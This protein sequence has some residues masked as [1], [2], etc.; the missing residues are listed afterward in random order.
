MPLLSPPSGHQASGWKDFPGWLLTLLLGGLL[1]AARPAVAQ[2]PVPVLVEGQIADSLRTPLP[3]VSVYLT[4]PRGRAGLVYGAADAAGRFALTWPANAPDTLLLQLRLI[5]FR[6]L[7]RAVVRTGRP[8]PDLN[9]VMQTATTTLNEVVVRA[10]RGIRYN[11]TTTYD[12]A[13]FRD[14]TQRTLEEVLKSVPGFVVAPDGGI[15]YK[16]KSIAG[17]FL[18]GENLTGAN[19]QRLTRNLDA[20]LVDKIQPVERFVENKLLGGL[21]RS[22]TTV[23]NITIPAD[24]KKPVFG[25]VNAAAALPGY[26]DATANVFSMSKQR[27]LFFIGTHNNIGERKDP[28]AES[29][30]SPAATSLRT[31]VQPV[32]ALLTAPPLGSSDFRPDLS[33]L[34]NETTGG[35]VHVFKPDSSRW[36]LLSDISLYHDAQRQTRRADTRYLLGDGA[37][38][39]LGEI[40]RARQTTN[41]ARLRNNLFVTLG[42]RANLTYEN[43]LSVLGLDFQDALHLNTE[44][45]Q[46]NRAES[47]AQTLRQRPVQLGQNLL[48][49]NRLSETAALQTQLT[50][51]YDYLP[52]HFELTSDAPERRQAYLG[53]P[54][55]G[56]LRQ[57][58]NTRQ[59]ALSAETEYFQTGR[60]LNYSAVLGSEFSS[61]RLHTT[62]APILAADAESPAARGNDLRV[63]RGLLYGHFRF[64]KTLGRLNLS[65]SVGAAGL[66]LHVADSVA[67]R[68]RFIY[69]TGRLA[70]LYVLSDIAKLQ[71]HYDFGQRFSAPADLLRAPVLAD[72]RTLMRGTNAVLAQPEQQLG[73]N[74]TYQNPVT[75][76]EARAGVLLSRQSAA[77]GQQAEFDE[78]LTRTSLFVGPATRR[79]S[80]QAMVAQLIYPWSLRLQI[81][82]SVNYAES[83]NRLNQISLR[84]NQLQ[85]WRHRLQLGT[86]FDFPVN[87]FAGATLV[88]SALTAEADNAPTVTGHNRRFQSDGQV[89]VRHKLLTATLRADHLLIN[90]TNYVFLGSEA[91]YAPTKGRFTYYL[92][93]KNLLNTPTFAQLTL[94]DLVTASTSYELLPRL[95]MPGLSCRF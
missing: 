51:T 16:G 5:G 62:L 3:G 71:M 36:K 83:F 86:A 64:D 39:A 84:R 29:L 43:R 9:L 63:G 10:R 1:L 2:Q 46:T 76:T 66:E 41:A 12:A 32:R 21:V 72:F 15:S 4:T 57:T 47:I 88:T 33:R 95:I 18:E 23:L 58:A 26:R 65:G 56:P 49:T 37:F 89:V 22:E 45:A 79:A 92:T 82:S 31:E 19:Y 85:L 11:D 14:G 52:Q 54:L 50:H 48:V 59:H 74:L 73:L 53:R 68:R 60:W 6:P 81:E 13:Q 34:N 70:A 90:Q 69:P 61:T 38:L 40:D 94:T 80:A 35:L 44:T 30:A 42:E 87:L 93:L 77:F 55:A 25:S 8:L 7:T 75:T 17:V 78:M 27:K 20:T 67:R 91:S 24:R 28:V